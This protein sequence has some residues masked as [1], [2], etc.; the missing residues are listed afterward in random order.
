MESLRGRP[1]ATIPMD[2]DL[3]ILDCYDTIV[4]SD[5]PEGAW[6]PRKGLEELLDYLQD[7][8]VA[9]ASDSDEVEIRVLLRPYRGRFFGVYGAGNMVRHGLHTLKN[10][11]RICRDA[12]VEPEKAVMIGDNRGYLDE[13]SA[14]QFAIRF[15]QVPVGG[16]FSLAS[17]IPGRRGTTRASLR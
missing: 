5:G 13:L 4:V 14:R 2:A 15:I 9:I 17:L 10:L 3:V 11:G 8:R 6:R 12:R 7:R 16:A 1:I